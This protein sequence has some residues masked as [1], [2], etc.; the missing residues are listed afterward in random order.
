MVTVFR[1]F[2]DRPS[3]FD[4]LKIISIISHFG[5]EGGTLVLIASVPGHCLSLTFFGGKIPSNFTGVMALCILAL[6]LKEYAHKDYLSFEKKGFGETT[7]C[8]KFHEN[9]W[10][11]FGYMAIC[12]FL[13]S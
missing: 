4:L 9:W 1:A 13:N 5:F 8:N 2:V 10:V 6:Q 12:I 11:D 7:F 3:Y